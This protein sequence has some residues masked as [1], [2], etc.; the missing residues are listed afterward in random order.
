MYRVFEPLALPFC[1]EYVRPARG[2]LFPIFWRNCLLCR[3]RLQAW[4]MYPLSDQRSGQSSYIFR[5]SFGV[6]PPARHAKSR[7]SLFPIAMTSHKA[8]RHSTSARVRIRRT[9]PTGG[10]STQTLGSVAVR[11]QR[12]TDLA[13]AA[14]QKAGALVSSSTRHI[15]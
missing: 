12:D 6:R 11:L 2:A 3:Y 9:V 1:V 8:S 5:R 7:R 15:S 4:I 13:A 14:T 10:M